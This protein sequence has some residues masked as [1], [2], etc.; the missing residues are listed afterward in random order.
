MPLTMGWKGGGG[1]IVVIANSNNGTPY[2]IETQK[3]QQTME[4]FINY[5]K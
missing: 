1:H 4:G 3:G 2:L 5:F